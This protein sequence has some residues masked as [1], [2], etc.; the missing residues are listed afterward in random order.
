MGALLNPVNR[1]KEKIKWG[2]VIHT[3]VLFS[4][5]TI[6][7]AV[8]FDILSLCYTEGREFPGSHAYPPGPYG[9]RDIFYSKAI[10]SVP[11][12]AFELGQWLGD[13]FLVGSVSESAT[14]V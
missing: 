7:A 13:R 9:Y 5:T 8:T 11:G 10:N 2:L 3:V 1:T 4:L 12:I 6:G 14:W